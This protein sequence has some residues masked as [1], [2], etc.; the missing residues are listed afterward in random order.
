[1]HTNHFYASQGTDQD[2]K[3]NYHS[4]V[5]ICKNESCKLVYVYVC[6]N[7]ITEPV[8]EMFGQVFDNPCTQ[9]MFNFVPTLTS[10]DD[11]YPFLADASIH[12]YNYATFHRLFW[13]ILLQARTPFEWYHGLIDANFF[14]EIVDSFEL[15]V[16]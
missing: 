9:S 6:A 8:I 14:M 16:E 15:V 5:S 4:T 3:R 13:H 11:T 2:L 12:T 7:R 10:K 1:M